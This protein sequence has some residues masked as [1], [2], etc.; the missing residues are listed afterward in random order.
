MT[1]LLL[2]AVFSGVLVGAYYTL[3][4]LGLAIV[5][6]AMRIINTVHGDMV[7][8]G[9]YMAYVA[10]QKLRINPV[11][12]IPLSA[13]VVCIAAVIV[14]WLVDRIREDRELN[15]LMLTFGLAI[16]FSNLDLIVFSADI[17]SSN[18]AWFQQ[19]VIIGDLL[20]SS[21]AQMC[22]LVGGVVA[23]VLVW[24]WLSRSRY[25][26]AIRAVSSYRE[27]AMLMGIN[28]RSAE[29]LSF[30]IAALLATIAGAAVYATSVI[31]PTL[32]HDI[33]IK[34]FVI[35]VL[36]GIGSVPG[37]MLA[38]VLIGV[39]EALT[40]TFASSALQDLIGFGLFLLVLV[41]R[42]TGLFGSSGRHA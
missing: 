9:G 21:R 1:D 23:T 37:I 24:L 17:R 12:A 29:L 13:I 39:A 18:S 22:M 31:Q 36:A 5:F 2:Q 38:S 41:F 32:G 20:Y 42:P 16:I 35:T 28:P 7:L 10:E 26:I 15:S 8:L 3:I 19:A 11:L 34:A 6:G 4:A 30:L 27:A 33:T 14:Y 25:G 40:V